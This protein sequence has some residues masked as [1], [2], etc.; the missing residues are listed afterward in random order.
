AGRRGRTQAALMGARRDLSAAERAVLAEL[1]DGA[2]RTSREF[3]PR[4]HAWV[5]HDALTV[6]ARRG[7][8]ERASLPVARWR[9]VPRRRYRITAAGMETRAVWSGL[10]DQVDVAID[11]ARCFGLQVAYRAV[12]LPP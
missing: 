6:L 10:A 12:R 9:G 4:P 11:C 3:A 7:L 5:L 8:V 2:W 1:A